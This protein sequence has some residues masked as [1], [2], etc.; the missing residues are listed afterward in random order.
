MIDHFDIGTSPPLAIASGITA[1]NLWQFRPHIDHV[2][3]ATGI[4][5]D[6]GRVRASPGRRHHRR[7]TTD[8][9]TSRQQTTTHAP[10]IA[11][12]HGHQATTI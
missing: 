10:A 1:E 2:L 9:R 4:N 3:V 6:E 8:A 7:V 5:D 12:E 11:T